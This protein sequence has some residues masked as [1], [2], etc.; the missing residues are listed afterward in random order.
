ME[1]S[2]LKA[3]KTPLCCSSYLILSLWFLNLERNPLAGSAPYGCGSPERRRRCHPTFCS[4]CPDFPQPG[5]STR[6]LCDEAEPSL[7][8]PKLL[9]SH[10]SGCLLPHLPPEHLHVE[11]MDQ[12]PSCVGCIPSLKNNL[13]SSPTSG[14][15]GLHSVHCFATHGAC[16]RASFLSPA[17]CL[18]CASMGGT[19]LV[20]IVSGELAV[21]YRERISPGIYIKHINNFALS[22]RVYQIDF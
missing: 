18:G 6:A 10:P 9:G 12:T 21:I 8:F 16:L 20:Q 1:R 14:Y 15:G 17:W 19:D 4:R 13:S 2:P 22:L 11:A 5:R 3:C 7:S